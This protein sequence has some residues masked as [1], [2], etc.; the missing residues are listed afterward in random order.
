M[1]KLTA[2]NSSQI[3][4]IDATTDEELKAIV[5]AAE[6]LKEKFLWVGSAG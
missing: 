4:V 6:A 2:A 3:I 1:L 5:E